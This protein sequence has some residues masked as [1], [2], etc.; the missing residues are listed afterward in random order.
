M[1]QL[2]VGIVWKNVTARQPNLRHFGADRLAEHPPTPPTFPKPYSRTESSSAP[3]TTNTLQIH[4]APSLSI[5]WKTFALHLESVE[6]LT[7]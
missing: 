1:V 3:P 4:G 6:W 5:S 2:H 7:N